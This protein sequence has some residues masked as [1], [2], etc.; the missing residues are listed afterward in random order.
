M[1][2]RQEDKED[3]SINFNYLDRVSETVATIRLGK[4]SLKVINHCTEEFCD[5]IKVIGGSE[6]NYNELY[7]E[8]R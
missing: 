2:S 7:P 8:S 5:Q 3:K 1:F 4:S 6:I